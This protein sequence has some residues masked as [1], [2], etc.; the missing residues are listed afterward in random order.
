MSEHNGMLVILAISYAWRRLPPNDRAVLSH[1][2]L[3]LCCGS[4]ASRSVH[5]RAFFKVKEMV[6]KG[7]GPTVTVAANPDAITQEVADYVYA[8]A[9]ERRQRPT[10]AQTRARGAKGPK[11]GVSDPQ[12]LA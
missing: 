8:L 2:N 3:S 4:E 10:P 5:E 11:P 1:C 7:K 9:V 12:A 6:C